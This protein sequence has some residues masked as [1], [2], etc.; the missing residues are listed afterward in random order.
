MGHVS[1]KRRDHR[2]GRAISARTGRTTLLG[3]PKARQGAS[4]SESFRTGARAGQCPPALRRRSPPTSVSGVFRIGARV[5]RTRERRRGPPPCRKNRPEGLRMLSAKEF[6][7]VL[8]QRRRTPGI[9]RRSSGMEPSSTGPPMQC[10]PEIRKRPK[11]TRVEHQ[12]DQWHQ[13]DNPFSTKPG[14]R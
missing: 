9:C 4:R 8:R 13:Q 10:G 3:S 7:A 6:P 2:M 14:N 1:L 11:Y 5:D 12:R